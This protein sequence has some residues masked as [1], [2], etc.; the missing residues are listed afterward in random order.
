MQ[1][2]F[3]LLT[4]ALKDC[5]FQEASG[6]LQCFIVCLSSLPCTAS[7]CRGESITH[8][9]V[10]YSRDWAQASS[11]HTCFAFTRTNCLRQLPFKN[12]GSTNMKE[13]IRKCRCQNTLSFTYCG[14][15]GRLW[16]GCSS[17]R[18]RE[19]EREN[20]RSDPAGEENS[21]SRAAALCAFTWKPINGRGG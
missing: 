21:V 14:H 4:F 7:S 5:A 18:E 10:G 6:S 8:R 9:A 19:G 3:V 11:R 15:A 20:T 1:D 12:R 17:Q 16:C 2:C 13:K